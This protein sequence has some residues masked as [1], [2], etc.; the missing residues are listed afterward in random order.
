MWPL[1]AQRDRGSCDVTVDGH[2]AVNTICHRRSCTAAFRPRTR[3]C[4]ARYSSRDIEEALLHV[5]CLH[6]EWR[7]V[8]TNTYS[9]N[10]YI[11][12]R[13]IHIS[14]TNTYSLVCGDPAIEEALRVGVPSQSDA[15][16]SLFLAR[17][18]ERARS[19][20]YVQ[21]WQ[22]CERSRFI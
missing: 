1:L 7:L 9:L 14:L 3:S 21:K 17:A 16:Y 5:A 15:P 20:Y 18:R 13:R 8:L 4:Y 2:V 12:P 22:C 6:A 11:F 19:P 10:E